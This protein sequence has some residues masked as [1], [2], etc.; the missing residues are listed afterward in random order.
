MLAFG[1]KS[2]SREILSNNDSE[3]S[4]DDEGKL[5]WTIKDF[6]ENKQPSLEFKTNENP[7]NI[8]PLNIIMNLDYSILGV[9]ARAIDENKEELLLAFN[10]T[11]ES[12]NFIVSFD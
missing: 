7:A 1:I 8:F 2:K 5:L 12:Q 6:D 4:Y 10:S 11:C 9:S 3:V